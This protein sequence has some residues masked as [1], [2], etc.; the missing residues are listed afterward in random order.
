MLKL[1]YFYWLCGAVLATSAIMELRGRRYAH[2]AF[3]GLLSIVFIG[4]DAIE[5]A[6]ANG[7]PLLAQLCGAAVIVLAVIAASGRLKRRTE[8][9]D[10]VSPA[11]RGNILF[12]PVLLIPLGT[13]ALV[14]LKPWL[15]IGTFEL[16]DARQPTLIALGVACVAAA[17]AAM[18][19]TRATPIAAARETTRLLDALSWAALLPMLLATLGSVF[20]ATG[21]GEAIAHITAAVIPTDSRLACLMAYAL[22]MVAFTVI[23]GNAF[24]AFP[25]M[26][27]GIGLPLLIVQ[28]HADPAAL[29]ALGM[30]T[31]YCGTLLTPMAAN[32]NVVPAALLELRDPNGVIKAQWP[33][34][35]GLFVINI[36]LM[37][38]C[39]FP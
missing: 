25:V 35:A 12:V 17:L 3:W 22:G 1:E 13:L 27:A 14:L 30:L 37:I 24:A 20:A 21:V 29:G 32:F 4:C 7:N 39:A 5:T 11:R 8:T 36:A 15:H 23:M 18:A 26:T 34:A 38:F 28:H 9:R 6:R 2:A 10:D 31:G 16:F 19:L 33:T